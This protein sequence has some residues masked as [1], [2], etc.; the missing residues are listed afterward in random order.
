MTTAAIFSSRLLY[1]CALFVLWMMQGTMQLAITAW[2]RAFAAGA[3]PSLP[4]TE[5]ESAS[6][7]QNEKEAT[8]ETAPTYGD[9]ESVAVE[10]LNVQSAETMLEPAESP[11][12]DQHSVDEEPLV[13]S[14]SDEMV[15]QYLEA[16]AGRRCEDELEPHEATN[17]NSSSDLQV[18]VRKLCH[19]SIG[20][21]R[22]SSRVCSDAVRVAVLGPRAAVRIASAAVQD[23]LRDVADVVAKREF[24]QG[25]FSLRLK[26]RGMDDIPHDDELLDASLESEWVNLGTGRTPLQESTQSDGPMDVEPL[27]PRVVIKSRLDKLLLSGRDDLFTFDILPVA[28]GKGN[29][30]DE[31]CRNTDVDAWVDL[32][33]PL[34]SRSWQAAVEAVQQCEAQGVYLSQSYDATFWCSETETARNASLRHV[35]GLID[36]GEES[37]GQ[38]PYGLVGAELANFESFSTDIAAVLRRSSSGAESQAHISVGSAAGWQRLD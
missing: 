14:S 3:K 27:S 38:V 5:L 17:A 35:V 18:V 19:C 29:D 2:A 10:R 12:L 16:V 24:V 20:G 13:G 34:E 8:A 4:P 1:W 28:L 21:A 32:V 25:V 23:S 7:T 37:S 6:S 22:V 9:S 15:L 11:A 36:L 31:S 30:E 26:I 33:G